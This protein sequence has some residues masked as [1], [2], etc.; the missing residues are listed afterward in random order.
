[1][2]KFNLN[3]MKKCFKMMVFLLVVTGMIY[4]CH[5]SFDATVDEL[6]LAIT[7]YDQDQDFNQLN[8]FYLDNTVAYITDE[9]DGDGLDDELNDLII[10]EV[11]SNLL[12]IG[13]TENTDT[14]GGIQADVGITVSALD[15]DV[16]YYYYYWWDYWYWYPWYPYSG[17]YWWGPGYPIWPGYPIYPSYS[18]TVGTVIIDMINVDEIE[19]VEPIPENPKLEIPIVWTG[20]IN[21]ILAGS[22]ENREQRLITTMEKVFMQSTYLHKK[23]PR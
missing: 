3:A 1:M 16:T 22:S 19:M 9:E 14:V 15:V 5:P 11:R 20:A 8:S 18:Y 2:F 23:S 21:G 12:G 4:S 17:T 7:K 10:D 13:W 6:D